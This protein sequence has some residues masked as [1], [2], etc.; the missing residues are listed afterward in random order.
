MRAAYVKDNQLD[1][2]KPQGFY[3]VRKNA[4]D[5]RVLEKMSMLK[6]SEVFT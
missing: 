2:E 6:F 3:T 1:A 4:V 5:M